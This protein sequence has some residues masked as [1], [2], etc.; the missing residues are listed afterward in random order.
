SRTAVP[1]RGGR[2]PLDVLAAMGALLGVFVDVG[3]AVGTGDCQRFAVVIL[4]PVLVIPVV[5]VPVFATPLPAAPLVGTHHV[6]GAASSAATNPQ[7]LCEP[8]QKGRFFDC[9]QRHRA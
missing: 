1:D 3:A 2:S 7:L 6:G 8:S 4:R 9:P 5:I